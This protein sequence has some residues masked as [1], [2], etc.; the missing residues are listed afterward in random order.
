MP[1]LSR[2]EDF[3]RAA[4][5][6]AENANPRR[7]RVNIKYRH[8]DSALKLTVTD[9]VQKYIYSSSIAQDIRRMEKLNNKL[10][11]KMMDRQ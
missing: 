1:T 4:I 8:C 3:E 6:L 10:I 11:I 5:S 7:F 2:F 9:D